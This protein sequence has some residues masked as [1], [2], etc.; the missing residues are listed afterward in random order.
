[1]FSLFLPLPLS[2]SLALPDSALP[3]IL[4]LKCWVCG[5]NS[6]TLAQERAWVQN[7]LT[8]KI[9]HPTKYDHNSNSHGARPVHLITATIKWIRTSR[10]SMKMTK[11]TETEVDVSFAIGITQHF[12][13]T[14]HHFRSETF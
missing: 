11:Q 3:S 8:F 2:L 6:S 4:K 1:L 7:G 12:K 9:F 13:S 5:T 14:S 10:L